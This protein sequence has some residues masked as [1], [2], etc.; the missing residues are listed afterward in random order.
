MFYTYAHYTPEGRLFYI[1]K[2]NGERAHSRKGRNVYWKRV[3]KKYGKPN[4]QILAN[5]DTEEEAFNHEILLINCFRDMGYKLCNLT[6]GGEGSLGLTPWNKGVPW[7]E[8]VKLKQGVANIGNKHW[9]GRK[10]SPE[11][12]RKQELARTK[13][14]FIGTNVITG[15]VITLIGKKYMKMAGFTSTHIY[16][17]SKIPNKTHKNYTWRKE[18]IKE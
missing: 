14:K 8:E 10:H 9:V 3:V 5:W 15:E 17:C 16:E 1:G 6:D 2:G 18:N 4:T 11:T 7:S 12:I 13:F